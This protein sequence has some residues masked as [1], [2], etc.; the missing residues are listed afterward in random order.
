ML[1]RLT[2]LGDKSLVVVDATRDRRFRLLETIRQYAA[3]KV[4][5]AGETRWSA[6]HAACI[7]DRFS[8]AARIWPDTPDPDW[9]TA[10][11][12]D[13]D[14]LRA[15]LA[16]CFGADGDHAL[17]LRLVAS[18]VP[19]WWTLPETPLVEGQRWFAAAVANMLPETPAIVQ[20]WLRVGQSWRDFRFGDQENLA[21]A[22]QAASLFRSAGDATGLG[23]SLWRAGSAS[24][25]RETAEQAEACLTE[26]ESVLRGIAPG[27][28]LALTLV[29]LGD[30]RFRQGR[31]AQALCNYQE[32]FALS[33]RTQ[34]WIGLV[35][36][37]SN[38][39]ELLFAQGEPERALR[40]L[41]AL[42]AEL[43]PGRRA[44]LMATLSAHLLLAGQL[45]EMRQVAEEAI[46]RSA[47]IGLTA[48][49]AWTI[50]AVALL[51]VMQGDSSIAARLAG[52]ART[53]HPSI[54]TRAGSRKVVAERLTERLGDNLPRAELTDALQEG[55]CW[56]GRQ[57][58]DTARLLLRDAASTVQAHG[59]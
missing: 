22:L 8:E 24:L 18:S 32:G 26:A 30:L 12:R 52:Y 59:H 16:W 44:P 40:Q 38:M 25:T 28:W 58:A 51:C 35:N 47:A 2:G 21:M 33:R 5:D 50:E 29:R 9:L 55:A 45:P 11:A 17:G 4:R 43:T 6:R 56:T 14:N 31:W 54:A 42:R 10:Y 49:L 23:A 20:G 13:A 41:R 34:F 1:D 3:E 57:A 19:L 36:G 37:G 53:V 46:D 7:A 15:A 27:K 48:A 39:A